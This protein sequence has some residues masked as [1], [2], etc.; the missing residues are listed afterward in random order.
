MGRL[1]LTIFRQAD[2]LNHCHLSVHPSFFDW[3][4]TEED[5]SVLT[6]LDL[7]IRLKLYNK[8]QAFAREQILLDKK[9]WDM[10]R[11]GAKYSI[12]TIIQQKNT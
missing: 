1:S 4:N 12:D 10:W 2:T 8:R 3:I 11:K 9:Y 7:L 6:L 5:K